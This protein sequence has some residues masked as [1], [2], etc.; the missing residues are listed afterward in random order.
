MK[1]Q[2]FSVLLAITAAN[3]S[4]INPLHVK[5]QTTSAGTATSATVAASSVSSSTGTS[6]ASSSTTATSNGTASGST[7]AVAAPASATWGTSYPP[8]SQISSGMPSEVTQAVT[9]TYS[10]GTSPTYFSGAEPLPTAFVF[11]A[12]DWPAQ[13]K[14]PDTSSS[15]VQEWMQ[16]LDGWDIPD[17]SPTVDGT[18]VSDPSNVA[19]AS[20]RGWWTCGGYT[21]DTDI[22][23]CPGKPMTW[24][25]SFDDG[26]AFYTT[27]LLHFLHDQNI[28]ATFFDV[29]SRCI[30]NPNILI[31]EYMSGHEIAVH[32]WS[33]P[34]LTTL[35]TAEIVAEL[36]W[37]R[38]A[39][40]AIIG[41][42]P[43][44]MR[45]PYGD[46]DDRVRAISLA[47]GMIPIIWTRT[48]SGV[49]FDTFDWEI[50][51]GVVTSEA[52]FSQFEGILGNASTLDDGFIVLEH[53]L[54]EQTVDMAIGYTLPA[55]LNHNPPF[56]LE[57][58][59]Q[60]NGI[61][62]T[63]MYV[64]SNLNA[65]F[66]IANGTSDGGI[67]TDGDG[68]GDAKSKNGTSSAASSSNGSSSQHASFSISATLLAIVATF[69]VA[70]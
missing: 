25:T 43:T 31:D 18:C 65:S 34:H 53:D 33:H 36:G 1:L 23:V 61:P 8:L 50:P 55:A 46:I 30:E 32:T 4:K 21:R 17:L 44:T 54:Y 38:K 59:G 69:V 64:E 29:G 5:R 6:S 35:T 58:I 42:T 62:Y 16:E 24:G 45:P 52:S 13:D 68:T 66:P 22:T 28:K 9:T 51:G 57:P 11:K 27:K 40:K 12:A 63:N 2:I 19:N 39:I 3:A 67:D 60:C 48:P 70:I 10:V 56:T 14:L 15:E 20:A 7:T 49:S 41:V 37:T 47:M 26:P